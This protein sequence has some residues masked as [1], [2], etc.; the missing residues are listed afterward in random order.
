MWDSVY[1]GLRKSIESGA[2]PPGSRIPSQEQLCRE[3]DVPRHA[4]RRALEL[5][6]K[7]RLLGSW[8]G[9][10]AYVLGRRLV[11]RINDQTRFAT[12][13]RENGST[14]RIVILSSKT[15]GHP[16]AEIAALLGMSQRETAFVS[17]ILHFVD[18]VPTAIGRHYFDP[19]RFPNMLDVLSE[20]SWTPDAFK[21][22]GLDSYWRSQTV[23]K[24][25]IP[26]ASEALALDLAPAQPVF[27]LTGRNIDAGGNPI[28]VTEA[29]VRGDRIQLLI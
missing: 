1:A 2:L 28:E 23:V 4:V 11:Y 10:G 22:F 27:E 15:R 24:T 19:R 5:L 29:I 7:E 20:A 26:T 21:L 6:K 3:Y 13:M 12:S 16:S 9:R 25:R 18:D 8:Q 14:V 17:E